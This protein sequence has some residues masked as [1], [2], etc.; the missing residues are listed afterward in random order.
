M[1]FGKFRLAYLRDKR[2]REVDFVV[3]RDGKPWFLVEVKQH[4]EDIGG[5]LKYYQEQTK[6][7][8]AFQAVIDADYVNVDCFA[9]PR[10]PMM[11]PA[12]TLLSQLL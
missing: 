1:G 8:F 3:A 2:Q 4:D 10:G 6:A 12:K 9:K 7:P 5:S 11:V